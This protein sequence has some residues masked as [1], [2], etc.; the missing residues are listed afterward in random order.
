MYME[1]VR[2]WDDDWRPKDKELT[3]EEIQE[4]KQRHKELGI[5]E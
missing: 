1:D 3:D 2:E 5:E 4:I